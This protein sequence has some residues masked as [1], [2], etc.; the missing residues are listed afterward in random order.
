MILKKIQALAL[1]DELTGAYNRRGLL[2]LGE[3]RIKDAK[4]FAQS[5]GIVYF[6]ID[7]LKMLNDEYGHRV[8]DQALVKFVSLLRG[9]CRD[10]DVIARIGG[11]E[12]V[13]MMLTDDVSCLETACERLT[14]S[15]QAL[16]DLQDT[17]SGLSVSFGYRLFEADADKTLDAMIDE[18]DQL[19]YQQKL[20]K[21]SELG[22][23]QPRASI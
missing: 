3:Q 22:S 11:D 4:R 13:A 6:D 2:T 20:K 9:V 12:F 16:D 19:M 14:E 23:V 1:S 10:S 5:I 17:F 7:N 21:K 8:G 15:F 18:T